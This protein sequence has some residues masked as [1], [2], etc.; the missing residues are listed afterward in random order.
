[1]TKKQQKCPTCREGTRKLVTADH[2]SEME[3][4][5]RAYP[6]SVRG[7]EM[8]I[9]DRCGAKLLTD[10]ARDRLEH[11]LRRQAGLL[12]PAEIEAKRK[13][14]KLSQ[15]D[16]AHFLGVASATVSRWE[17]GAQIQ[18]RV[19]NDFMKAFFEVPELRRYLKRL[20]GGV[21]EV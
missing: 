3:H 5:G 17:T 20:R 1:M 21:A 14:L 15:K 16:F 19:M 13:A 11:E 2:T 12:Q 18:Q 10:A 7:I 8:F 4:D 9:C 6:I